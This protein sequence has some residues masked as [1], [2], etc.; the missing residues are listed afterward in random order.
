MRWTSLVGFV[1]S[2]V[3]AISAVG[4]VASAVVNTD[5]LTGPYQ[6]PAIAT[7]AL[8]AIIVVAL[9]VVGGKGPEW[10]RNPYW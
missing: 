5:L 8:C 3:V 2:L 10:L 6:T 1:V 7:L 4:V 9:A